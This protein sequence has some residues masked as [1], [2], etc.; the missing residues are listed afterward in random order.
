MFA[1]DADNGSVQDFEHLLRS[2]DFSD[3]LDEIASADPPAY[4]RRVFAEGLAAPRLSWQLVQQLAACGIVLD[5]V[6]NDRNYPE[7]EPELI[8]DWRAHQGAAMRALRPAA[9][10]SLERAL[11]SAAVLA[12]PSASAELKDLEQ[13]VAAA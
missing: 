11:A 3:L 8:A 13:R 9:A 4:L 6:A 7:L 10:A 12:E 1:H 5:A 2:Y